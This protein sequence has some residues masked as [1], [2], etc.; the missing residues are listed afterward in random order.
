M[1]DGK[2]PDLGASLPVAIHAAIAAG[3]ILD[4][5]LVSGHAGFSTFI[6]A[7]RPAELRRR[8]PSDHA[9]S[10]GIVA[11][12]QSLLSF[13]GLFLAAGSCPVRRLALSATDWRKRVRGKTFRAPL[14]LMLVHRDLFHVCTI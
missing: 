7:G 14:A 4:C 8:K 12:S 13:R 1:V 2:V 6:F 10:S 9:V 11:H 3:K 5:A